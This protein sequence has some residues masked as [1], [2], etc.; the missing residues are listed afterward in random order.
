V[1]DADPADP[2]GTIAPRGGELMLRV[3]SALVLV[4]LA[5]GTA[6]LGGWPFAIFWALA[7][8]GVF[9]EWNGLVAGEARQSVVPIG[10]AGLVVSLVLAGNGR[11]TGAIGLVIAIA[12]GIIGIAPIASR[13]LRAWAAGGVPYAGAIGM[14][15]IVLRSDSEYGFLA[16]MFLFA[17][18]WAT[19]IVA[20]FLGRLIGGPKLLPRVSPRKTWSGAIS[21]LAGA[22]LAGVAVAAAAGLSGLFAIAFVAAILSAVAQAG[23]LFESLLK[24]KFGAKDSSHLIP[25]HGGLMDRLDGFV[26]AAAVAALIG[27]LRGGVGA[28]ARGL[29]VW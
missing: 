15:P 21:G 29:L 1:T 23:D 3:C 10:G 24:R 16:A 7:A 2:S 22:V 8:I 17:S 14:A 11:L 26:F 5:I 9:W 25:G 28:P 18:V 13:R 4:P 6:Y 20:Y 12:I 19:D 27:I